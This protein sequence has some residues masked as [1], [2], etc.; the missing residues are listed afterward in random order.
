METYVLYTWRKQMYV[1]RLWF[2][3]KCAA[4]CYV[5]MRQLMNGQGRPTFA[6]FDTDRLIGYWNYHQSQNGGFFGLMVY[7]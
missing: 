1:A 7:V 6:T 5:L 3:N 2:E 4:Q